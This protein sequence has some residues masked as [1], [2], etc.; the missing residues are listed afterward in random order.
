MFFVNVPVGAF[1]LI[2]AL[3]K[4]RES[5]DPNARCTDVAGLV[6]FSAALFL[7]VQALLRGNDAGWTSAQIIGS[8]LAG[9]ALLVA[10]VVIEV[11]QN[12]PMLDVSLFRRPAFV[13]VQLSTF[14]IGAGMFALFPFLSIYLQDILGNSPL[15]AG[16]RFLPITIFVFIVPL[17]TR[18]LSGRVPMWMLLATSLAIVSVGALLM[19]DISPGWG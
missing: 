5:R 11:R 18:K 16:L 14:C 10:F 3:R 6:S 1:A 4:V 2:V 17:A 9:V 12:R 15:G 19:A 8:V 7:I 13:G